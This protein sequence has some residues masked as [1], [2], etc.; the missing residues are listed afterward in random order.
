MLLW[1]G[2]E[3]KDSHVCFHAA[4]PNFIDKSTQPGIGSRHEASIPGSP[5]PIP[6]SKRLVV[7]ERTDT[8]CRLYELNRVKPVPRGP[9][10][11]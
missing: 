9:A 2:D 8:M 5:S 1:R 10:D 3:K 7:A 4:L 6:R 11:A